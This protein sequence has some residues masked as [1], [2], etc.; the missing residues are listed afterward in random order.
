MEE[1]YILFEKEL[2]GLYIDK[3]EQSLGSFREF[4]VQNYSAMAGIKNFWPER[5]K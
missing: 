4:Q 3:L 1:L 5:G 2:G